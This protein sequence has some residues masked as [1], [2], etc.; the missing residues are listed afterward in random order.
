MVAV[1]GWA[2]EKAEPR[3]RTDALEQEWARLELQL[4]EQQSTASLA[5]HCLECSGKAQVPCLRAWH[6]L[7]RAQP[8]ASLLSSRNSPRM[9]QL[10]LALG[11]A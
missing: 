1:H 6:S 9:L 7:G 10:L 4:R 11:R 8:S 3:S 5:Q 2:E